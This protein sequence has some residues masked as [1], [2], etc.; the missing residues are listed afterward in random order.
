MTLNMKIFRLPFASPAHEDHL[1]PTS[2]PQPTEQSCL[3]PQKSSTEESVATQPC[4]RPLNFCASALCHLIF[5]VGSLLVLFVLA[6]YSS[7]YLSPPSTALP[8]TSGSGDS[9]IIPVW[10]I[11]MAGY[12]G[13]Q[14]CQE[15]VHWCL[16]WEG[17][18]DFAQDTIDRAIVFPAALVTVF[19]LRAIATAS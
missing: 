18:D 11:T 3:L 12:F 10:F 19:A 16:D 5:A 6:M 1:L 14:T 9:S 13:V 4:L 17:L 8:G 2:E 15:V 7:G